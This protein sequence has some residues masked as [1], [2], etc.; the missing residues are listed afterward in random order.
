MDVS[1]LR[2][3]FAALPL[4]TAALG[5]KTT[6]AIATTSLDIGIA[7]TK[8]AVSTG[9]TLLTSPVRAVGAVPAV[10]KAVTDVPSAIETAIGVALENA[11]AATVRRCYL[12]TDRAWPEVRGQVLQP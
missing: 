5:I 9:M 7:A 10:I 6:A 8:I 3:T 4:R 12:C 2:R 1:R 11:G